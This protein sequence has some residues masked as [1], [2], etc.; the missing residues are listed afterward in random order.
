MDDDKSYDSSDEKTVEA[1][2]TNTSQNG[3][4]LK[5]YGKHYIYIIYIKY[6]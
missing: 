3:E 6:I 5:R 1:G 4:Q 2:T